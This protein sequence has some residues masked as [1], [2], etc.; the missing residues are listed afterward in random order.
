MK[1]SCMCVCGSMP[2]GSRYWPL[3]SSVSQP[4]GASWAARGPT[5]AILP[6]TQSTS[7]ANS[8]SALTTVPPRIRRLFSLMISLLL[9]LLHQHAVDEGRD[10]QPDEPGIGIDQLEAVAN[11]RE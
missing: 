11:R 8:R 10:G 7:A 2:P 5:T 1:G 9:R 6:S 4:E 3:P